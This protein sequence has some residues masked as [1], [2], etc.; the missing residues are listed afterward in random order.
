MMYE[1]HPRHETNPHRTSG[2]GVPEHMPARRAP[3][4]DRNITVDVPF[5]VFCRILFLHFEMVRKM[6]DGH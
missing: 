3:T 5:S 4:L 1:N 2:F 6:A